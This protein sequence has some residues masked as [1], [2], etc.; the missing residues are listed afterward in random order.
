MGEAE[1]QGREVKTTMDVTGIVK[2]WANEYNGKTSYSY[3][4][5]VKDQD[6][7][8]KYAKQYVRFK[9][10][11]PGIENGTRIKVIKAFE[12]GYVDKEGR[13]KLS[14][15]MVLEWA[16]AEDS[17]EDASGFAELAEDVPF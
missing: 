9:G 8:V 6:G 17:E 11:D 14:G 15:I 2:I 13:P 16:P 1:K 3:S 4:V 10:G 5:K 7:A 12:T